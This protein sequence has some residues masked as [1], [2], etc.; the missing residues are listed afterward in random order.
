MQ[1]HAPK[2]QLRDGQNPFEMYNEWEFKRKFR[3]SKNL[4]MFGVLPLVEEELA[5]VNN[6]SLPI[7]PV[8][9][10]L[11]R[12]RFYSTASFQLMIGDV[13]QILQPTISRIIFRL[14]F[15]F[16]STLIATRSE[17]KRLFKE[18]R[19]GPGAIGLSS[20][21]GA[22]DCTHIRLVHTRLY[23]IE[24]IYRNRKGYFSLNVQVIVGPRTKI[25][26]IVSKWPG[27]EHDNRIFQNSHIYMRYR[28]QKLDE[29][30]VRDAG[31]PVLPFLLTPVNNPVT[32]E[33]IS[34]NIIHGRTRRIVKRTFGICTKLLT[35]T[36][37]IVAC[38]VLHNLSLI[39]NDR[40]EEE[41]QQ[42]EQQEEVP[43]VQSHWQ[44]GDGFLVRNALIE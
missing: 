31:N 13:I 4:V 6:H 41:K 24:E 2:R 10:L 9:Q 32:D 25:L 5:K 29:M 30:L 12:L 20:I 28:Q 8:L 7:F 36:T 18:L 43:I 15:V 33:E 44:P 3:F 14:T 11:T 38:A 21:D 34:Y 39:L 17:N 37:I 19:Y 16:R 35:S 42:D 22:I 40:L 23:N 27:C 1:I 26:D